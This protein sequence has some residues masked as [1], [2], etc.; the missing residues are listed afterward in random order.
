MRFSICFFCAFLLFLPARVFAQAKDGEVLQ[1]SVLLGSVLE[2]RDAVAVDFAALS[3]KPEAT[4]ILAQIHPGPFSGGGIAGSFYQDADSGKIVQVPGGR[5]MIR[6]NGTFHILTALTG[7]PQETDYAYQWD[8]P[9]PD[10]FR[11]TKNNPVESFEIFISGGT[12]IFPLPRD[13]QNSAQVLPIYSIPAEWQTF[14]SPAWQYY[15]VNAAIFEPQIIME[16]KAKLQQL[17]EQDNPFLA[18]AACRTLA[19]AHLLDQDFINGPLLRATQLRQ[20]VFTFLLLGQ[21]QSSTDEF[22]ENK[23]LAILQ[24]TIRGSDAE[25]L[26]GIALGSLVGL[27][28]LGHEG[29]VRAFRVLEAIEKKPIPGGAATEST[30]FIAGVIKV[31][32]LP[33]LRLSPI[34]QETDQPRK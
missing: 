28:Q 21:T 12:A 9:L 8:F 33:L 15:Q 5:D 17:L 6:V 7:K 32:S 30:R 19:Q 26:T 27:R 34:Y 22:V 29:S 4:W 16:N 2:V 13:L 11:P 23:F 18:I 14:V 1:H 20:A 3:A 25:N 31:A 10:S 24:Q